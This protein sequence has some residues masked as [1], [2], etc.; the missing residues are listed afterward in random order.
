MCKSWVNLHINS[1]N[2]SMMIGD[3]PIPPEGY[4]RRG[5]DIESADTGYTLYPLMLLF[6]YFLSLASTVHYYY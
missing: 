4:D 5:F 3:K 1:P 6:T 2:I